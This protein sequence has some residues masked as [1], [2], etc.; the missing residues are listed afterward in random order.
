MDA[1]P[2]LGKFV[3]RFLRGVKF[4]R[5]GF[6]FGAYIMCRPTRLENIVAMI[7]A[8]HEFNKA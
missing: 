4:S 3:N 6:V 2:A 8:V 5:T 7:D 1:S